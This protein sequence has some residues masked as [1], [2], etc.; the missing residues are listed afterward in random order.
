MNEF[1][2]NYLKENE[3]DIE[4]FEKY[5]KKICKKNLNECY[6]ALEKALKFFKSKK[7]SENIDKYSPLIRFVTSQYTT[8]FLGDLKKNKKF[9]LLL[10]LI[11][12]RDYFNQE[13]STT[14]FY[15]SQTK[16]RGLG[17]YLG[18]EKIEL[19]DLL[20]QIEEHLNSFYRIQ[21]FGKEGYLYEVILSGPLREE[22]KNEI[23]NSAWD[24]KNGFSLSR[25]F[26]FNEDVL[27]TRKG[28]ENLLIKDPNIFLFL[29][30]D[31]I[32]SK[33]FLENKIE[34]ILS[35]ENTAEIY[36][37]SDDLTIRRHF[38]FPNLSK[39]FELFYSSEENFVFR[40]EEIGLAEEKGKILEGSKLSKFLLSFW[41]KDPDYSDITSSLIGK[42]IYY[43]FNYTNFNGEIL[44]KLIKVNVHYML[45][46]ERIRKIKYIKNIF[47]IFFKKK[48]NM[49]NLEKAIE[50][51]EK[52]SYYIVNVYSKKYY[53]D[54]EKVKK[55]LEKILDEL[56]VEDLPGK[57]FDKLMKLID[58]YEM[59]YEEKIPKM[60]KEIVENQKVRNNMDIFFYVKTLILA[61]IIN[62]FPSE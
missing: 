48:Y 14:I 15:T 16:E 1:I 39:I 58:K 9:E 23:I 12:I 24:E 59:Y 34:K 31:Y 18:Q 3:I 30:I 27:S 43:L 11:A 35:G 29:V 56:K 28:R 19:E 7:L 25:I 55:I 57:F 51:G 37:F 13:R 44:N 40:E 2:K 20:D 6:D 62:K 50:I 26:R 38:I 8:G 4:K 21:W 53:L 42:L 47:K 54:K 10:S 52:I 49:E 22:L 36:M 33:I 45:K 46:N 61:G 17:Y 41:I 32:F 5:M 60:L